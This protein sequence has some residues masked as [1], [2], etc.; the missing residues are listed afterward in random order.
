MGRVSSVVLSM[1]S[2]SAGTP[3]LQEVLH[4]PFGSLED[5][6][7]GSAINSY[8]MVVPN[9][10]RCRGWLYYAADKCFTSGILYCLIKDKIEQLVI[11]FEDA[12]HC[13]PSSSSP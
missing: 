8:G 5:Y 3:S 2:L 12:L 4:R 7:V 13:M 10:E 9:L 6:N 1:S 11:A